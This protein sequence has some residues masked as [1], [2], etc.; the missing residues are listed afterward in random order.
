MKHIC[1]CLCPSPR[2]RGEGTCPKAA[3]RL[4]K[5]VRHIPFS[6]RAERRCRQ[7]DEGQVLG[8]T[9]SSR[10]MAARGKQVDASRFRHHRLGLR[11]L[12]PRLPSVGR[13]QE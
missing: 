11:R 8:K 6:P 9:R 2:P 5:A 3:S 12:C 13:R 4:R 1:P 10:M 7:A